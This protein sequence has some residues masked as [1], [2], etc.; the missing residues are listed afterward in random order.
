MLAALDVPQSVQGAC[1]T[2]WSGYLA[3]PPHTLGDTLLL[4]DEI[5]PVESPLD[6]LTGM[7]RGDM[8]AEIELLIDDETLT[9]I[10]AESAGEVS[11]L[12]AALNA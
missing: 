2:L 9:D 7:S 6:R 10:L 12:C 5:S 1:E 8:T 3:M 4:A 11:E